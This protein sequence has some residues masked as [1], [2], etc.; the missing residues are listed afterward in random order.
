MVTV[1]WAIGSCSKKRSRQ[2]SNISLWDIQ[3][4]IS[5]SPNLEKYHQS[6]HCSIHSMHC[7]ETIYDGSLKSKRNPN[8]ASLSAYNNVNEKENHFFLC[9]LPQYVWSLLTPIPNARASTN[10]KWHWNL[11]KHRKHVLYRMQVDN[12]LSTFI[13]FMIGMLSVVEAVDTEI[14]RACL[15]A[16]VKRVFCL[17]KRKL[18]L[19]SFAQ[20]FSIK[21]KHISI[22]VKCITLNQAPNSQTTLNLR[23]VHCMSGIVCRN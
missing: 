9:E 6:E 4:L 13:L 15:Q 11:Y 3:N 7:T 20:L 10:F 22:P 18:Y 16:I 23:I 21:F 2:Y 8:E 12:S 14:S 19:F 17:H 1:I 5:H